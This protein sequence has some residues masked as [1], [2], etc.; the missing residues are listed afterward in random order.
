MNCVLEKEKECKNII[1]DALKVL[2][3]KNLAFI[4]HGS[5]FPSMPEENSGFG[6]PNSSGGKK[7]IA[8]CSEYFNAIQ[9]GPQGITKSN[10]ASP[11]VSTIFSGNPLFIDLEQLTTSK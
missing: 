8:F 4:A 5:S 6:T 10:D 9:L 1:H 3:K 2:G 11:Y 7:L